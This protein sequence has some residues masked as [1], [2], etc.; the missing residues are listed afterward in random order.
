M[1]LHKGFVSN[2]PRI[3]IIIVV[4]IFVDVI[5]ITVII[6]YLV[7]IVIVLESTKKCAMQNLK[8]ASLG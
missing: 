3:M 8:R 6:I 7:I 1:L 2:L 5:I 4:I